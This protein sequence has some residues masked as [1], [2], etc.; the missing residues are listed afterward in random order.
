MIALLGSPPKSFLEGS[1]IVGD[2][3]DKSGMFLYLQNILVTYTL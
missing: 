3:F 2:Y 1:P